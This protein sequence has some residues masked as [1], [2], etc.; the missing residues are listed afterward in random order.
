M[1]KVRNFNEFSTI[2]KTQ[3][4]TSKEITAYLQKTVLNKDTTQTLINQENNNIINIHYLPYN[5]YNLLLVSLNHNYHSKN[6]DSN[7][8]SKYYNTEDKIIDKICIGILLVDLLKLVSEICP[9]LIEGNNCIREIISKKYNLRNNSI[10]EFEILGYF[11]D[12]NTLQITLQCTDSTL[13]PTDLKKTI[14]LFPTATTEIIEELMNNISKKKITDEFKKLFNEHLLIPIVNFCVTFSKF[15]SKAQITP[16]NNVVEFEEPMSLIEILKYYH[17]G[18]RELGILGKLLKP[19]ETD[20]VVFNN[21]N[22]LTGQRNLRIDNFDKI[23]L[24]SW[25]ISGSDFKILSQMINEAYFIKRKGRDGKQQYK[26]VR[27]TNKDTSNSARV[28]KKKS[29]KCYKTIN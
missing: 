11:T 17:S 1:I 9:D 4:N 3:N 20:D 5:I 7:K 15:Q 26:S 13:L 28:H 10:D 14:I 24:T 12:Q 27:D 19:S 6:L 8:Y 2:I 16:K 29:L 23:Y 22:T 18:C 25:N 21:I